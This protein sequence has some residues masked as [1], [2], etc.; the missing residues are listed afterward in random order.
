MLLRGHV[1]RRVKRAAVAV[2]AAVL[3]LI[4]AVLW[5]VWAVLVCLLVQRKRWR[6]RLIPDFPSLVRMATWRTN[7]PESAPVRQRVQRTARERAALVGLLRRRDGDACQ[8]CGALLDFDVPQSHPNAEEVDHIVPFSRGGDCHVE[9]FQLAHR[10]CNQSK[11]ADW[12]D[13]QDSLRLGR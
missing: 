11:G 6:R 8:L 9:N 5:L 12:A 2:G 3:W 7:R 1:G 10:D 13:L 4:L